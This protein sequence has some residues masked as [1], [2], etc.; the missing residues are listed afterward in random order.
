MPRRAISAYQFMLMPPSRKVAVALD[1]DVSD[2]LADLAAGQAEPLG[3]GPLA[4]RL[5]RCDRCRVGGADRL[6]HVAR[7]RR[8][9]W[10]GG[11]L[12]WPACSSHELHGDLDRANER[13]CGPGRD[14]CAEQPVSSPVGD[15][16]ADRCADA[17]PQHEPCQRWRVPVVAGLVQQHERGGQDQ[18]VHA[19]R[20]QP[21]RRA[22]LAVRPAEPA[23]VGVADHRREG[24][25]GAGESIPAK[26]W[27]SAAG[28]VS[29][30]NPRI[31]AARDRW[32]AACLLIM[33]SR[34][35]I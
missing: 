6:L 13:D 8:Y 18:A 5:P 35:S 22:V 28:R 14:Q 33:S 19:Q 26:Y 30:Q 1:I 3:H 31:C 29:A 15:V 32:S 7:H 9:G 10:R 4:Q 2:A 25:H 16:R 27:Y 23:D 24:G 20:E 34:S 21:G 11:G 17:E 12:A